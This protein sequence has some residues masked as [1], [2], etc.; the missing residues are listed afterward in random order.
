[1]WQGACMA[2]GHTWQGACMAGGIRGRGGMHAG[3]SMCGRG[4]CMAVGGGAC[5]AGETATAAGGTRPT[6][7]GTSS[8]LFLVFFFF[9]FI[10]LLR[11]LIVINFLFFTFILTLVFCS[12]IVTVVNRPPLQFLQFIFDDFFLRGQ[13]THLTSSNLSKFYVGYHALNLCQWKHGLIFFTF[14]KN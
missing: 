2:G 10:F 7:S 5:V 12:H 1:M 3:G 6:F 14:T 8:F 4:A 9:F 11:P 13:Q